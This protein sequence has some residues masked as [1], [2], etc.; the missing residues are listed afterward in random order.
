[1]SYLKKPISLPCGV[2]LPNRLVKAAMSENMARN[3]NPGVEF[4]NAYKMWA[5]G[6]TGLLISGNVMIDSRHL[7][8]P[9]NVVIEK[10]RDNK[11]A[12]KDWAAA[13]SGTDT[14]LWIQIN[15]PG[16]QSPKFLNKTPVAPSAIP[17]SGSLA[18]SFCTPRVLTELEIY[19]IIE[20]FGHSAKMVKECGFHGV[21]IHGAHGYLVSQFLS[22]RHN[23]RTD[24]F[25]G[26]LEN[27]MRFVKEVYS[28]MRAEVGPHF[29]IGIKL[30]SADFSKGGFSNE[31][32]VAVAQSLSAMGIDMI[33]IS[34]GSYEAPAMMGARK[35]STLKREAYFLDY[36]REIKKLIRCPLMVTGG[37]RTRSF[38]EE[39]LKNDEVDL[40]GMARPLAI[41]LH[42]CNQLL[43][44]E[45]VVSQIQTLTSGFK[46]IDAM[47]P[48]EVIWYASQIHRMGKNQLPDPKASVYPSILKTI[49]NVGLA[50]LKRFCLHCK[51]L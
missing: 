31:D 17:L 6:G 34:G 11:E 46:K 39:V 43:G 47:F 7:G 9:N 29:P 49:A 36:A 14:K 44:G 26:S 42:L 8:E 10:G 38:L 30:N 12:L 24:D 41:N 21:Q 5:N 51:E 45:D 18:A 20:R 48:L 27:R 32:A 13:T 25:G 3:L 40:I 2:T 4:V 1:M 19:E 33:E 22:P 37:F 15:H 35:D 16:K 28:K 50:G 23:V